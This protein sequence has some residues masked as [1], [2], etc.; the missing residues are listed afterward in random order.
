MVFTLHDTMSTPKYLQTLC[1]GL[2]IFL[3][4][5]SDD[6][7]AVI[8]A[9]TNER[10]KLICGL[11]PKNQTQPVRWYKDGQLLN[12]QSKVKPSMKMIW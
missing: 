5:L 12:G 6:T 2:Y 1:N 7:R 4:L 9:S 10:I 3:I 8:K 11:K